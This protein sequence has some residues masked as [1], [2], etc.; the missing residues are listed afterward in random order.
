MHTVRKSYEVDTGPKLRSVRNV[1]TGGG[2][3]EKKFSTYCFPPLNYHND[4]RRLTPYRVS[5]R[6]VKW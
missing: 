1:S 2:T 3:S 4:R 6:L 5:R